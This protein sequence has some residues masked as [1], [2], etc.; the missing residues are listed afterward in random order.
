[1]PAPLI[2]GNGGTLSFTYTE[3]LL[4]Y[5]DEETDPVTVTICLLNIGPAD[6]LN[7]IGGSFS[8]NFDWQYDGVSNCFQGTQNQDILGGSG[9]MITVDFA[10]TNTI[11]CPDN[12]M[13]F[14]ANIQPAACMNGVNDVNDDDE[15]VFTC[16]LNSPLPSIS[17]LDTVYN[18]D[19][20]AVNALVCL[21]SVVTEDVSFVYSITDGTAMTPMDYTT[22]TPGNATIIAGNSCTTL[23]LTIIDDS[24]VENTENVVVDIFN[25][26]NAMI[27][28]NSG[29]VTIL[30]NDVAPVVPGITVSDDVVIEGQNAV[31][32]VCI[33]EMTTVDVSVDVSTTNGSAIAGS[34]YNAIVNQTVT[35]LAGDPDNCVDVTIGTI[36]DTDAEP[37]ENFTVN[38]TNPLNG[39]LVDPVG[40][41]MITDNDE[42]CEAEAPVL[43]GN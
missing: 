32:Q 5:T 1:M 21:D 10:Q 33:D 37:T 43:S 16:N 25:P 7:S 31:V 29:L 13:G 23:P 4:D 27:Q 42:P 14:N 24:V 28:D 40:E 12:Q 15:A 34:D 26:I 19:A 20:G 11:Q 6:G 30:D 39:T 2:N 22:S 38:L 3:N 41:V 9:G 36:D 8:G 17:V 18:E 35:I